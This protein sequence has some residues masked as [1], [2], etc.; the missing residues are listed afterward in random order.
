[1]SEN[2]GAIEYTC[3][4]E[5]DEFL[6]NKNRLQRELDD[7][8][9]RGDQLGAAMT[10][11]AKAVAGAIAAIQLGKL[12]TGLIDT[13][14]QFDVMN[15][16]LKT[17]TGSQEAAN[18]EFDR[19]KTFAA[20][21]PYDLEQV[22]SAFTKMKALGLDPSEKALTSFGNTASAMG[23]NLNQMV[24]AVADAATGEFERLKEFGIKASKQGEDVTFTFQG[25]ET[26]IKASAENITEY[27]T[28]LGEVN[29][30]GAMADRMAT[31]DGQISNLQDSLQDLYRAVNESGFGEAVAKSVTLATEAIQEMTKSIKGGELTEYFDGVKK[32]LPVVEVAVMSLAGAMAS[33]LVAAFVATATQATASATAMGAA[34]IAA[35]GFAGAV[36]LMGGPIGIAITALG[37]L[38]LN[39]DKVSNRALSAA[40]ISEQAAQR[41]KAALSKADTSQAL[42]ETA[43][44]YKQDL[45][46]A[47]QQLINLK[48]GTYGKGSEK[49]IADAEA[50]IAAIKKAIQDVGYAQQDAEN[51]GLLKNYKSR[52]GV[53]R[54]APPAPPTPSGSSGTKPTGSQFD[55]AGYLASLQMSLLKEQ[56][57]IDAQEAEK[58]R[59]NDELL[60]K[61]S[62][63]LET[64]EAAATAI[65]AKAV[66]DREAL[67]ERE[68]VAD[69]NAAE[70]KRLAIEKE[71]QQAADA[72]KRSE[73]MMRSI[74][75]DA[76]PVAKIEREAAEKQAAL[77]AALEQDHSLEALWAQA[78]IALHARK[79]EQLQA[80]SE[81]RRQAELANTSMMLQG[82]SQGFG[83]MADLIGQMAGKQ[84]T[85]YKAMFAVSKAFAIADSIVKIQQGVANAMSLPWPMNLAAAASA[86]SAAAGIVATIKGTSFGGGRQFGGPVSA[87][88]MYRVNETGRPEMFTSNTGAQYML[89]TAN[90]NVTPANKVGGGGAGGAQQA[91]PN[92]TLS[93]VFQGVQMPDGWFAVRPEA[94]V[95]A[96]ET[97]YRD[98]HR[99]NF[100]G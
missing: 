85:A 16:S 4:I 82:A 95:K 19:L 67:I 10:T 38:A 87:G 29:F 78:T 51:S 8:E 98:G 73:E 12:I 100:M 66:A 50:R 41:I 46:D 42:G 58:L 70:A 22:V 79:E 33:R 30:A 27:L 7:V 59:R 43:K 37:L 72:R 32:V 84:S 9:K 40:E 81:Q 31:L 69:L 75:G 1:M 91:Q 3:S 86:A 60:K 96:L 21:T 14:R 65:K 15:A 83:A 6:R 64:A 88:S 17:L 28:N 63:S 62:I 54:D 18:R 61:K 5:L 71:G 26:T 92:V 13:Q 47:Q 45:A 97:A 77:N 23:K 68:R 49:E 20:T 11:M 76:D 24:E 99:A 80:I 89:P 93:P 55:Q 48:V 39:W 2:V 25:V 53:G 94:V 34:T 74:I 36:A 52:E 35:R 44:K 57:L 90:G 56:E